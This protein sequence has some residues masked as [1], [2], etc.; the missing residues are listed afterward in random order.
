M[1]NPTSIVAAVDLTIARGHERHAAW[2]KL[3]KI[4]VKI[5]WRSFGPVEREGLENEAKLTCAELIEQIRD[6]STNNCE[7]DIRY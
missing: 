6:R 5:R 3:A 4:D 2:P 1:P 7:S